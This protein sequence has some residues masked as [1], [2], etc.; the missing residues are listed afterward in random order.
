M[1]KHIII[2]MSVVL[3]PLLLSGCN[4][5][6]DSELDELIKNLPAAQIS[7]GKI[8]F[9]PVSEIENNTPY[10][11]VTVNVVS[12]S[13]KEITVNC[14]GKEYKFT[15]DGNTKIFGGEIKESTAVTITYA[16]DLSDKKLTAEIITVLF[17]ESEDNSSETPPAETA[18]PPATVELSTAEQE[19]IESAAEE[20]TSAP[21]T[22]AD[23][24]TEAPLP[25]TTD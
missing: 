8:N 24:E 4:S 5:E 18:Q 23:D 7:D 25:D 15:I 12:V 1:K 11:S 13:S 20:I 9:D 19:I 10:S 21:E 17:G 16:G 6:T 2:T 22:T 3:L 14:D